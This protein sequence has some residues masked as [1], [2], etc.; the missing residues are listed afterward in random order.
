MAIF[1]L[2]PDPAGQCCD[3]SQRAGPC[4]SCGVCPLTIP[5]ILINGTT[6]PYANLAAAQTAMTLYNKLNCL[7]QLN[8]LIGTVNL[9]DASQANG[10]LTATWQTTSTTNSLSTNCLFSVNASAD[11]TISHQ[12]LISNLSA[13]NPTLYTNI[14]VY[15]SNFNQIYNNAH[16]ANTNTLAGTF[17]IPITNAG[18]YYLWVASEEDAESSA[19]TVSTFTIDA[20]TSAQ[21]GNLRA[22]YLDGGSTSYL[23]CSSLP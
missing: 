11:S 6:T 21:F 18:C 22:A 23:E 14:F 2:G 1:L 9:A 16:L 7:G 19:G 4:D 17:N 20:G 15:D 8:V 3:C 13:T 12:Y 10:V 5:N